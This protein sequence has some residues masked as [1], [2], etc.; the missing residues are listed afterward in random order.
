MHQMSERKFIRVTWKHKSADLSNCLYQNK[1]LMLRKDTLENYL[2]Q[3]K[4]FISSLL[5]SS[6]LWNKMWYLKGKVKYTPIGLLDLNSV[7]KTWL[8]YKV[9]P[10]EKLRLEK[11]SWKVIRFTTFLRRKTFPFLCMIILKSQ[12]SSKK[13]PEGKAEMHNWCSGLLPLVST[14][15]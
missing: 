2:S 11:F 7:F 8:E 4:Y 13:L 1:V 15:T 14:P 10:A 9:L 5:W 3:I 12:M 6:I